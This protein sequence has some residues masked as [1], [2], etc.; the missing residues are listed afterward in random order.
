[1]LRKATVLLALL[2]TTT[3]VAA[4]GGSSPKAQ[5]TASTAAHKNAGLKLAECMRSHGVPDFPDPSSGNG[6]GSQIQQSSGSG[7]SSVTVDGHQLNVS[8]P[9]F[10]N[11]MQTCRKL[12]PHGPPISG[13]QLAKLQKG[14]LKMAE[15]MRSHGVPNFP[16]P[17]VSTGPNGQG[18]AVRIGAKAGGGG[19]NPQSPAFQVAQKTCMPLMG[20]PRGLPT[21]KAGS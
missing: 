18:V 12:Q 20:G 1:M 9:A 6:G 19:L 17:Q 13:A 5:T 16:D 10:Q 15:C 11:A 3:A 7:G 2:A 21:K 4:C 14:A 8:A